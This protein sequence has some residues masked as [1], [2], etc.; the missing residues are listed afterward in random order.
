MAIT[1]AESDVHWNYFLSIEEDLVGLTRF[2][3]FHEGNFNCF[4][5]EN[6]RLL[7]AAG[8]EV[9]VVCKQICQQINPNS[10]SDNIEAYRKDILTQYPRIKD[11][12]VEISRYGLKLNPWVNWGAEKS[13]V[14]W[15]AYNDMKHQRH[16]HYHQA[17]LKNVLNALAGLYVVCLYL[18]KDKAEKGEL[19]PVPRLLHMKNLSA[20][21]DHFRHNYS[22]M[23]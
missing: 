23:L 19:A 6:T 21:G 1:S 20:R 22:G 2:I 17:T 8:A 4:S 14:W 12:E 5:I 10:K 15:G 18:Y 9:D 7:I 3:E 11:I 13:P 16:T